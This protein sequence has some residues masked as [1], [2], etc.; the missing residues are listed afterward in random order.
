[1]SEAKVV[2]NFEGTE[3]VIQ[4]NP[5]DKIRDICQKYSAKIE[6]NMNSLLFLYGGIKLNMDL[7][8]KEQANSFD[9]SNNVMRVLVYKE[10]ADDFT[11][12]HCGEKIKLN[13]EKIDEIISS[14]NNIKDTIDGIKFSIDNVIRISTANIVN[15]QLKNITVVLNSLNEDIK[16]I[17]DKLKHLLNENKANSDINNEFPNKNVIKGVL[18]VKLNE[19]NN[20]IVLFNT[21][22][23]NGID[24]YLN[25]KKINM[26]QDGKLWKI[27]YNFEKDGKYTFQIVFNNIITNMIGFFEKCPN[28]ISLDFSN[29]NTEKVTDMRC[30]FNECNILKEIK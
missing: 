7:R 25:N 2:F 8:F 27:D 23:K 26:I 15:I 11:C 22:I 29:F 16:K 4:C 19:I 28:I 20:K 13:T 14:N 21:E 30:M 1:M 9:R 5:E 3:L 17:N 10:D 24:V 18:D 6:T 12:P